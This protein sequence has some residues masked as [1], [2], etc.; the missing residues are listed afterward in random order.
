M[1]EAEA[2][3]AVEK[4]L[5]RRVEHC[6]WLRAVPR[7]GEDSAPFGRSP[8]FAAIVGDEF[9]TFDVRSPG[10]A[11]SRLTSWSFDDLEARQLSATEIQ[12]SVPLRAAPLTFEAA[13]DGGRQLVDL[14]VR[15]SGTRR[16]RWIV[17]GL[18]VIPSIYFARVLYRAV[19]IEG[20]TV[21][22]AVP[23]AAVA[24]GLMFFLFGILA[25]G[26]IRR[27]KRFFNTSPGNPAEGDGHIR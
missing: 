17:V 6:A 2:S 15:R 27:R 19:T 25:L 21:G 22:G 1:P 16:L 5:A 18:V 4:T 20:E 11:V 13:D 7:T 3:W 14:I 24:A 23:V 12:L 10:P 8:F 26:R 9:M